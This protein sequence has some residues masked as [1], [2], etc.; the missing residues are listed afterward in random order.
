MCTAQA[1][2]EC[3]QR[4]W[5]IADEIVAAAPAV[6]IECCAPLPAVPVFWSLCHPFDSHSQ[7]ACTDCPSAV[8]P[9]VDTAA[10][11]KIGCQAEL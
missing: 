3:C 2:I 11:K 8:A 1:Q 6:G 7:I 5:A 4:K 9:L 10:E